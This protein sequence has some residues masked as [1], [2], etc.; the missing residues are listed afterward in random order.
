MFS[1]Y[2]MLIYLNPGIAD[3]D[4]DLRQNKMLGIGCWDLLAYGFG[5]FDVLS[6]ISCKS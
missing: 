4:G 1:I 3:E 5:R 2:V 6:C